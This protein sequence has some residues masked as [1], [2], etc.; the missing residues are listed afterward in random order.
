VRRT[1]PLAQ[2]RSVQLELQTDATTPIVDAD[3]ERLQQVLLILLDNAI[4]HTP[5]GGH[6]TVHLG[7]HGLLHAQIHVDDTGSGIAA[8]DV[9]RIFD[10]FYRADKARS[11]GGTGLGLA[12]AKMLVEA[13]GGHL[14]LTSKLQVG[15]QVIISLPVAAHKSTPHRY[16]F[17]SNVLSQLQGW[18]SKVSY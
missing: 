18:L 13:H 12:I 15:T 14:T 5:A 8:E 16:E 4:K 2:A 7:N 6:V 3:P 17:P 10:R 11:D 9:P 1:T